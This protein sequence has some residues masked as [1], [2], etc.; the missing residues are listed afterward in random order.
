M[1][2]SILNVL[3][4]I[5]L[6]VSLGAAYKCYYNEAN[7][8]DDSAIS[9]LVAIVCGSLFSAYIIVLGVSASLGEL[10]GCVKRL[11]SV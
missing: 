7:G 4:I 10:L 6:V 9:A 8:G 5:M 2:F 3:M 1:F 11:F